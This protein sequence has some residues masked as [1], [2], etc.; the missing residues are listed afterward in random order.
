F[1]LSRCTREESS[2]F[3]DRRSLRRS[4]HAPLNRTS[5]RHFQPV[6][7]HVRLSKLLFPA[8]RLPAHR[9][10]QPK[11]LRAASISAP[12]RHPGDT[13]RDTAQEERCLNGVLLGF[14]KQ[15]GSDWPKPHPQSEERLSVRASRLPAGPCR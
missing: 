11:C 12:T 6:R 9:Y 2:A 1:G 15:K 7:L 8:R 5:A 3:P 10:S 14:L 13:V 4:L